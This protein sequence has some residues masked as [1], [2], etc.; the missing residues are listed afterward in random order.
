MVRIRVRVRVRVRVRGRGGVRVSFHLQ[1]STHHVIH[2]AAHV[3]WRREAGRDYHLL[4]A[5]HHL[6]TMP[7]LTYEYDDN[8]Q[9]RAY[10]L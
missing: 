1:Q 10:L 3:A 2:V 5:T 4:L 8:L 6:L 9:G 7:M